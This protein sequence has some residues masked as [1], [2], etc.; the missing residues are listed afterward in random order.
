MTARDELLAIF[1]AR[2]PQTATRDTTGAIMAERAT[3]RMI[4]E[5]GSAEKALAV[6]KF[7]L[8]AESG[9]RRIGEPDKL[10]PKE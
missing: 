10:T 1:M 5:C 2:R 4:A 3:D 6:A 7:Q 8:E 9:D